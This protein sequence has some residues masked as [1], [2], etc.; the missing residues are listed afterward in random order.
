MSGRQFT[1]TDVERLRSIIASRK[2]G[3]RPQGERAM[4][5]SGFTMIELLIVLAIISIL[6]AISFAVYA[7]SVEQART[8]STLRTVAYLQKSVESRAR[9]VSNANSSGVATAFKRRYDSAGNPAP[10][11]TVPLEVADILVRKDRFK[12]ALPTRLEDLWGFDGSPGTIDDS[13]LWISW[14]RI[15][16]SNGVPATDATPRP[17]GHRIDLENSELL[18]LFLRDGQVFGDVGFRPDDIPSRHMEDANRNGIPELVDDWGNPIRF[19]SWTHR[20]M[21]AGGGRV[22]IDRQFFLMTAHILVGAPAPSTT[23]PILPPDAYNHPLNQDPD[24]MTGALGAAILSTNFADSPFNLAYET[25]G[26]PMIVSCLPFREEHYHAF[27]TYSRPLV[28]SAGPD[29]RIGL[30]EPTEQS[31]PFRR[32]GEP[33][34]VTDPS[35]IDD[36]ADDI[37]A[38]P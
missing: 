21:R 17:P 22:P 32:T 31:E 8:A 19:Y 37:T 11:Q 5:R 14:K 23:A 3:R 18:F 29:G 6:M 10:N 1:E 27:D 30:V 35:R 20:L 9:S 24:D 25:A 13:P 16:N 2:P 4:K 38:R 7:S 15:V 26:P 36:I 34:A 33:I 28:V 12:Q